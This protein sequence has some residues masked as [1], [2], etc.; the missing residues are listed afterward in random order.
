MKR[1]IVIISCLIVAVL[2]VSAWDAY[3]AHRLVAGI[4]ARAQAGLPIADFIRTVDATQFKIIS[5]Q[6]Q[7]LIVARC[8]FGRQHCAV[9]HDGIR[10]RSAQA[11]FLD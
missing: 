10:I 8:G 7:T 11:A 1:L 5:G 9:R 3:R 6:H 4:C 2:A